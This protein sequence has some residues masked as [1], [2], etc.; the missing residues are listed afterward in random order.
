[1]LPTPNDHLP[2]KTTSADA[3]TDERRQRDVDA[4]KSRTADVQGE[5]NYAAARKDPEA[6]NTSRKTGT[7][8]LDKRG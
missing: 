2:V 6:R 8:T 1:M 7:L 3:S 4:A 5:G